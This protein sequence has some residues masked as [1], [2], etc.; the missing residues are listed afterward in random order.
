MR[1]IARE[2]KIELRHLHYYFNTKSDLLQ[3]LLDDTCAG[4]D[5]QLLS[6][7]SKTDGTP[8]TRFLACIDYLL[9]D[10]QQVESNAFF[11]EL[12]ALSCHD[13]AVQKIL[14]SLYDHYCAQIAELIHTMHPKADQAELHQRA[15][16]I[17]ALIE[18]LTLFIG[19]KQT[20]KKAQKAIIQ[21]AR[22]QILRIASDDL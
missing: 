10:N 21:N 22:H 13:D 18:G 9:H 19:R 20:A 3:A 14:R 16:L 11:F 6:Q 12:W 17:V 4:Y 2:S 5:A 1:R 7:T 15:V 8:E